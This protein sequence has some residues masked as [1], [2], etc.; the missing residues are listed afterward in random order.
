MTTDELQKAVD[1]HLKILG[2]GEKFTMTVA[3]EGMIWDSGSNNN[4]TNLQSKEE[5]KSEKSQ[6]SS[7]Q[8]TPSQTIE[9]ESSELYF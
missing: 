5:K 8:K 1:S 6:E 3:K 2:S 9:I 4:N 7:D